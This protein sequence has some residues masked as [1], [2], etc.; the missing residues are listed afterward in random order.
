ME[1]DWFFSSQ[2]E[3]SSKETPVLLPY[4][5]LVYRYFVDP[6][7]DYT[8]IK[9]T[10]V[11]SWREGVTKWTT[12]ILLIIPSCLLKKGLNLSIS[13][14]KLSKAMK[15]L[16]GKWSTVI[17]FTSWF[18]KICLTVQKIE[19]KESLVSSTYKIL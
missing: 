13:S 12:L 10:M 19:L 5:F 2:L 14:C 15:K 8:I 7:M 17:K 9:T 11:F 3:A 18:F 1:E 6:S 16:L 4:L